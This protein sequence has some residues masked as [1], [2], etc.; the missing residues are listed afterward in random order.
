MNER[1]PQSREIKQKW[2]WNVDGRVQRKERERKKFYRQ[3][4][5]TPK[6]VELQST[7]T[8]DERPSPSKP[9]SF[10]SPQSFGKAVKRTLIT[11]PKSPGKKRAIIV[12]LATIE[13]LKVAMERKKKEESETKAAV[14]SFFGRSD[15]VYTCPGLKDEVIVY[16][17]GKEK[18]RKKYL[19]MFLREAYGMFQDIHPDIKIGFSTFCKERPKNVLLLHETPAD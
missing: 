13:G 11:L 18:L 12:K 8:S 4:K 1:S 7:P 15:V 3:R 6:A 17:D 16:I 9:G 2:K 14:S 19:T 10:K 5:H